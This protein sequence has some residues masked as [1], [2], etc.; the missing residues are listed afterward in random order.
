MNTKKTRNNFIFSILLTLC[1]GSFSANA[2]IILSLD[3]PDSN[4]D[5]N[6]SFIINLLATTNTP[7]DA[8]LAWSLDFDFDT[9]FLSLD[10]LTINPAFSSFGVNILSGQV[11][12]NFPFPPQAVSGSNLLLASFNFTALSSGNP[13]FSIT[14]PQGLN[15]GFSNT[16]GQPIQYALTQKNININGI[17]AVPEPATWL[18]LLIPSLFL[19]NKRRL[20][21]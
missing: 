7:S 4:I 8:F 5:I 19:L 18:L 14:A 3:I 16:F 20:V 15:S 10:S 2:N 21:K 6:D 17:T 9:N 12:F 1:L 11:P 13:L